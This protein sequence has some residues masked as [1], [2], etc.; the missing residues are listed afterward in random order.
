MGL[1][2]CCGYRLFRQ[3]PEHVRTFAH[4]SS[5]MASDGHCVCENQL[6]HII[7]ANKHNL[8]ALR[9]LNASP[10]VSESRIRGTW[11]ILQSCLLTLLASIYTALHLNV[12]NE[13][14]WRSQL[15]NKAQWVAL[16]L[17]APEVVLYRAASQF[18]EAFKFRKRMRE[19]QAESDTADKNVC[20]K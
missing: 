6:W 2:N 19:L 7:Q 17:L 4:H 15:R 13:Q 14:D 1:P 3:L 8:T 11:S 9:T 18:L 5:T 16:T 20:H 12:P 10:W